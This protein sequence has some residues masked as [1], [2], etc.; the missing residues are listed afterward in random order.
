M[1]DGAKLQES[2]ELLEILAGKS[3]IGI[4]LVQDSR[5]IYV[6]SKF[7]E[8]TGYGSTELIGSEALK[9]VHEDDRKSVQANA[10]HLLKDKVPSTLNPTN[11]EFER[12]TDM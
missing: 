4:Y 11:F 5:F 1:N 9:Y 2:Q 3:L 12:K 8:I 10:R 7:E 6:N